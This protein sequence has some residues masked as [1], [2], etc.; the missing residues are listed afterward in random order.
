M[1]HLCSGMDIDTFDIVSYQLIG[2]LGIFMS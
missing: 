2:T 1:V